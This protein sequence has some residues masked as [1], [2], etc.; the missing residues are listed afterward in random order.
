M[1]PL[2]Q[3]LCSEQTCRD[4]C[5]IGGLPLYPKREMRARRAQWVSTYLAMSVSPS[6]PNH[7]MGGR[8]AGSMAPSPA[9]TGRQC[10][11][12]AWPVLLRQLGPLPP[13][14]SVPW[15]GA[16]KGQWHPCPL[17]Q[18]RQ[19]HRQ[20]WP[21]LHCWLGSPPLHPSFWEREQ[22]WQSIGLPPSFSVGNG[23]SGFVAGLTS[24]LC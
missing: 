2:E 21:V 22:A 15:G 12:Q 10:H 6:H 5:D 7:R 16:P 8:S 14:Q 23:A 20:A 17:I 13:T 11:H 24:R 19:R 4:Y 3:A 1:H 18:G 9:T